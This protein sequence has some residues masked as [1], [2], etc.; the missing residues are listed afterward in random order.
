LQIPSKFFLWGNPFTSPLWPLFNNLEKTPPAQ[1]FLGKN[2]LGLNL[3]EIPPTHNSL[4]PPFPTAFHSGS[5]NNKIFPAPQF[6][7]FFLTKGPN[8]PT[9]K[10]PKS[11]V[12]RDNFLDYN[13]PKFP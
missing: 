5:V 7:F 10:S 1:F 11:W 3:K 4:P 6:Y 2:F 8:C 12:L 13:S 9:S